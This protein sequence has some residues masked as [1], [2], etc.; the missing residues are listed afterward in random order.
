MRQEEDELELERR[1]LF[2]SITDPLQSMVLQKNKIKSKTHY[3]LT[4]AGFI[5]FTS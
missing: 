5:F 1:K 3:D 2:K 4:S